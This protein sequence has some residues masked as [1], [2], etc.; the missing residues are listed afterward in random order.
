MKIILSLLF[1]ILLTHCTSERVKPAVDASIKV[2][3]LPAQES[4]NSVITFSDSGKIKA[5]MNAGH[6]RVFEEAKETL[7]DDKIKID[8]FDE[9]EIK[10][11]TLNSLR[12]RVDD[13][14]NNLWAIDSVVAVS[15]SVTL[16][17]DELMWRNID[18]K[19]VSDKFVRIITPKEKIEGYGFESDQSLRNYVIY[20]I[21]F[22]TSNEDI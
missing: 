9:N 16:I 8:F 13:R 5:I 6:L 14:T 17:T 18:R 20:R 4:W 15:D 2:E 19:I 7:L 3:E 10:T 12:G 22:V 11:T 1:L 21:T